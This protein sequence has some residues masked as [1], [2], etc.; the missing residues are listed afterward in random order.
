MVPPVRGW[1]VFF[2]TLVLLAGLGGCR[3]A[4]EPEKEPVIDA[5]SYTS[6]I[7]PIL[8]DRC[9]PCHSPLD[10]GSSWDLDLSAPKIRADFQ[11]DL[12][13][14][15]SI[16]EE[17]KSDLLKWL[18]AA[19]P[20]D[21]HWAH[22]PPQP[23][24]EDLT[25]YLAAF[26]PAVESEPDSSD[27]SYFEWS[28]EPTLLTPNSAPLLL[29][30]DY[31]G[32]ADHTSYLRQA[33]D[34]TA[35]RAERVA[36][37]TFGLQ[38]ECARCHQHPTEP[39]SPQ[40]KSHLHNL[41]ATGYAQ[42]GDHP[43]SPPTLVRFQ[44]PVPELEP[45]LEA[46]RE[47]REAAGP[48]YQEWLY[49]PDRA[50]E[51]PDA[52]A[53]YNFEQ[54]PLRNTALG[55]PVPRGGVVAR[56]FNAAVGRY[57]KGLY[58]TENERFSLPKILTLADLN[59]PGF[60][61]SAWVPLPADPLEHHTIL[62]IGQDRDPGLTLRLA[63]GKIHVEIVRYWPGNAF[64]VSARSPATPPG[65]FAHLALSY[66]GG[67]QATDLNL[68]L[69]G[70]PLPLAI[71]HNTLRGPAFLPDHIQ[72]HLGGPSSTAWVLDQVAIHNRP[73]QP[74]EVQHLYNGAQLP[75]SEPAFDYYL[76]ALD[77][78]FRQLERRATRLAIPRI[79]SIPV[80]EPRSPRT[81]AA[82][83]PLAAALSA[84]DRSR[85]VD[86]LVEADLFLLARATANF[87]WQKQTGVALA[88][89]GLGYGSPFPETAGLLDHLAHFLIENDWDEGALARE[90]KETG[91]SP[92]KL[93]LPVER[94]PVCPRPRLMKPNRRR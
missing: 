31:L 32:T 22:R 23:L 66:N 29:A 86:T 87:W 25:T 72:W 49:Q 24:N 1:V 65:G 44:P 42:T 10:S 90:L 34:T 33:P 70:R 57:G 68:F 4:A 48:S 17:E 19:Q 88:P 2:S 89:R 80:M 45:T 83:V 36:W 92:E 55:A 11:F 47:H 60:T 54:S 35:A 26:A 69:N 93:A 94:P 84:P 91:H 16:S 46:L 82:P 27:N 85:F 14:P 38:A 76:R 62:Q 6:R 59:G 37:Q 63:D 79:T 51:V 5:P 8:L 71:H 12:H 58:L 43:L 56:P 30:G 74:V 73:L 15:I 64:A 53:F 18:Q 50:L 21:D 13:P 28:A 81:G 3:Q 20:I 67:N 75:A 78:R 39:F 7:R 40:Q 77:P 52:V 41:F 61:F 9:F